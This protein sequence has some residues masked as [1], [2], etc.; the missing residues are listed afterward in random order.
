MTI[1]I[2]SQ[3]ML[4]IPGA[5]S[6]IG[7]IGKDKFGE[8]MKKNAQA[9]GIN[10]SY[11]FPFCFPL[12]MSTMA[13]YPLPQ[14]GSALSAGDEFFDNQS[15]G[16]SL[17]SFGSSDDHNTAAAYSDKDEDGNGAARAEEQSVPAPPEPQQCAQPTD[18]IFLY[19]RYST[20][21]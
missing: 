4:Q 6:Y 11:K 3:W 20:I 12:Q 10:V 2:A 21:N 18:D 9:A 1:L 13:W 5:T 19:V 15:S 7:C 8:E 16:W 14:S 17:W